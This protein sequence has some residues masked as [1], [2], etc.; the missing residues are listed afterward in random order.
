M[1][2]TLERRGHTFGGRRQTRPMSDIN[3]T[4]LVDVM[5]VLLI[6]FMITAPL[7]TTGVQV[8]LP[9]APA[10]AIK[11]QDEPVSVSIDREGKVF[12]GDDEVALDALVVRLQAIA[13][14]NPDVRV[15]VRGDQGIDYGRVMSVVGTIHAAGL[16]QVALV[17]YPVTGDAKPRAADGSGSTSG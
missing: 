7:L 1:A 14:A 4:P 13:A 9:E 17:T 15:F 5:L 2:S 10:A 12:I 16:R 8:D 3:V 11:G 6:I